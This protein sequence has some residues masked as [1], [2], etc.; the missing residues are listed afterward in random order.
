MVVRPYNGHSD[1][2]S[3]R[4]TSLGGKTLIFGK[5]FEKKPNEKTVIKFWKEFTDRADLYLDVLRKDDE[6]SDDYM[7]VKGCIKDGL[8][9]CCLDATIA[10]EFSFDRESDP[11]RF[12]FRHFN[13]DY[14][15]KAADCLLRLFPSELRNRVV[16]LI[17]E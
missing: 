8:R 16:F 2:A 7:F 10:F 11:L 3:R 15:K 5:L 17:A 9:K 12:T 14:L 4:Y 13:D 6:Y 1:G